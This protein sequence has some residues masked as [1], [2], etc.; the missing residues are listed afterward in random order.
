[1]A[2][3][4]DSKGIKKRVTLQTYYNLDGDYIT[5]PENP[6]CG[7]IFENVGVIIS[8]RTCSVCGIQFAEQVVYITNSDEEPIG[9]ELVDIVERGDN[10]IISICQ[11]WG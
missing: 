2:M 10:L 1:M 7:K 4:Y 3:I 8:N 9:C 6:L 5:F 11:D